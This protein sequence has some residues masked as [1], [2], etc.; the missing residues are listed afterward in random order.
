MSHSPWKYSKHKMGRQGIC[1]S[2][3]RWLSHFLRLRS[4]GFNAWFCHTL[5]LW[6]WTHDLI[7]VTWLPIY[8]VGRIII[9]LVEGWSRRHIC[10]FTQRKKER[11]F[12]QMSL[13]QISNPALY[14]YLTT[15]GGVDLVS[16]LQCCREGNFWLQYFH[17]VFMQYFPNHFAPLE[18]Y[19]S[20]SF[21]TYSHNTKLVTWFAIQ[22][23]CV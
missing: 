3:G 11:S 13:I 4:S 19:P 23:L 10:I 16:A 1:K 6:F 8:K 20:Y 9:S 18:M 22:P 14:E 15:F 2:T 21:V 7:S 12:L 17:V 5:L